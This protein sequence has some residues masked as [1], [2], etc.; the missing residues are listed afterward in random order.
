MGHVGLGKDQL[1]IWYFFSAYHGHLTS[2]I[3]IS[4]YKFNLPGGPPQRDYVHVVSEFCLSQHLPLLNIKKI[5]QASCPDT[6]RGKYRDCD[7]TKQEISKLYSDEIEKICETVKR[8]KNE[9]ICAFIA[10]SLLSCGG[11]VI[12][13]KNYLKN[14]Y[15]HVREAGG[16]CIADEVQVGFGRLGKQWW[17]FQLHDVVPD[18]VTMGKPMGNGHPIAAVVTTEEIAESFRRT[19]VEYFNT[20]CGEIFLG[21]V[22]NNRFFCCSMEV[23]QCLVL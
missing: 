10:E 5:L 1:R 8:E 19:G 2:L 17:G 15:N 3:D 21:F 12:P 18:I 23:I 11:Q 14:V 16:V 6:Y 9:K 13:P 22:K 4:H 20:V 7:Y